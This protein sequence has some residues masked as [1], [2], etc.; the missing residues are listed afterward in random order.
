V[1]KRVKEILEQSDVHD[2]TI[3]E[4]PLEEVIRTI[5]SGGKV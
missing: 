3:E 4:M 2:L 1:A 5:F